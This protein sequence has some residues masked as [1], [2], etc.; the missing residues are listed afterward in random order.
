MLLSPHSPDTHAPNLKKM[1]LTTKLVELKVLGVLAWNR[2]K[3]ADVRSRFTNEYKAF[4]R[5]Y[6][7]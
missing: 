6:M 5:M 4:Q 3:T 2:P 7:F 1:E